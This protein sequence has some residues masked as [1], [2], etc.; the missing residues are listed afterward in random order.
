MRLADAV[1]FT[2]KNR[3]AWA[4]GKG[5]KTAAINSNHV[6]RILGADLSVYDIETKHFTAL[7]QQLKVEGKSPATINRIS[8][9]L[10]TV[11]SELRQHGYKLDLVAFKRQKENKGRPEFYTE[12]EVQSLLTVASRLDDFNLLHDSILFAIKTGCR[13]GEMLKLTFDDIDIEEQTITFRDVKTSGDHVIHLHPELIDV[14]NRRKALTI[15]NEVFQWRDKDQLLRALR[16]IQALCG[17]DEQKCWHTL[18]HT[19]ATWLLERNVPVRSVMGVL[20]H[21]NINTTLRYA[22][23]TD[24]SIAAAIEQI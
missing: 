21:S 15:N 10:S 23:Y 12:D 6:I 16:S 18:R 2:R 19:T 1:D 11:L 7:T 9:A 24:R 14:V 20:N 4:T 3:E 5:A 13:Q 22:K 17:I 8:A